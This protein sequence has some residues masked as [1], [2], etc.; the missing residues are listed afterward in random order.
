MLP[1][2]FS[3]NSWVR[4]AET[5]MVSGGVKIHMQWLLQSPTSSPLDQQEQGNRLLLF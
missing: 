4:E 2:E 5:K 3:I 1:V